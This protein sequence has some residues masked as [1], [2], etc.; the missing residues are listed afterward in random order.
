MNVASDRISS[1]NRSIYTGKARARRRDG[2]LLPRKAATEIVGNLVER[3]EPDARV[4]RE[5]IVDPLEHQ[6]NLRPA[7]D[8]RMNGHGEDRVI[9]L[10]I[11]PVELVAPE[12]LRYRAA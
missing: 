5:I 4:L 10:A 6:Q 9:V 11:D 2:S 8:V 3:A 12:L 7:G 1:P